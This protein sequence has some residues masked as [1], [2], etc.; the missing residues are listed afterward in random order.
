MIELRCIGKTK[1]QYLQQA[2]VEYQKRLGKF[3]KF[4]IS[5]LKDVKAS[6]K[7]SA[8][9]IKVQEAV[10]FQKHQ[11]S[12]EFRILLD[13]NGKTYSSVDF[14]KKLEKWLTMGRPVVFMVGGAYGFDD[15][16]R[17]EADDMLSISRM[18]FSHQLIRLLFVEQLYRGFTILNNLPYHNE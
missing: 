18:T 6:K 4:S 1:E 2:I 5:E 11:R 16:I 10:V 14:S 12:G 8:T 15:T 9:E 3:V 13:E 17:A 7:L